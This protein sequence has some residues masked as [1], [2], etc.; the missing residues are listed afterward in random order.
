MSAAFTIGTNIL[1]WIAICV[2]I[3][4]VAGMVPR[5]WLEADTFVTRIRSF[6]R[7]GRIYDR[8]RIR[9]W[10]DRL[11]ESNSLGRAQ[12]SNKRS[13]TG[14]AGVPGYIVETRRAEYVHW[15]ILLAGP[16]FHVWSPSWVARIMTLFGIGFNLPF[17]AVQRFNRGRA[18]RSGAAALALD[19]GGVS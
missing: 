16:F 17:I 14:R 18:V 11:P 10:K 4:W 12:R 2:V 8:V 13:L 19:V 1:V 5:P 9:R 3:G 7:N 15:A 6:E